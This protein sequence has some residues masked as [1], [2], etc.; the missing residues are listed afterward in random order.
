MSDKSEIKRSIRV[1]AQSRLDELSEADAHRL[2][3]KACDHVAGADFFAS[4]LTVMLYL[5]M[6]RE[7]D[8]TPL[9][10]RCFQLG[11]T[12]CAPRLNWDHGRMTAVEVHGFDDK[13]EVRRHGVREP[14]E[15]RP[16]PPAEIDLVIVP[17]LAFDASGERLGR[18]GGF[19][20]RFLAQ[21]G[22][23][24]GVVRCGVGYDFQIVDSIPTL[25]HDIRL[26][27]IVTDRRIIRI[28]SRSP[29]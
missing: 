21:P 10:L 13:F 14:L 1:A 26:D 28:G 7:L 23:R 19:Y 18:G 9:A 15:G 8:V 2:S 11:K 20:D 17:G 6:P 25:A 4:A 5:P 27:A 24:P 12:V 29:A 16:V 3:L 22:F